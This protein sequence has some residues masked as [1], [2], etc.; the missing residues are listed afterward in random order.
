M[1]GAIVKLTEQQQNCA[2]FAKVPAEDRWCIGIAIG[3]MVWHPV[4]GKL[5]ARVVRDHRRLEANARRREARKGAKLSGEQR[6]FTPHGS[7]SSPDA[8]I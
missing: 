7:G 5:L 3:A 6:A 4:V 8:P 2:D 1:I